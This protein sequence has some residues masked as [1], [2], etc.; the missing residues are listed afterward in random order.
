[1]ALAIILVLIAVGSVLFHI[2]SPW[3]W[4]TIASNWGGVDNTII[5][6]FW[7]TG[8]AFVAI[9]FFIA[10]C[11]VRYRHRKGERAHYQPHNTKLEW[12]LTAVTSV[13]VIAM[14]APGLVVYSELI[15]PPKDAAIVEVLGQQWQW[16]FRYPGKDGKLG[17]TDTRFIT[18]DN[19]FGVNPDDP[20]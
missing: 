11:I 5:I 6:T 13:G 18:A 7:I 17:T 15:H 19:P 8:A 16:R 3:W 9:I 12:T 14:L 2:Y 10:Y 20:N 1:M 4:D